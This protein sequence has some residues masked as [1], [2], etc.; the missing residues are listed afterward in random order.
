MATHRF[1]R[2]VDLVRNSRGLP[3][4]RLPS[5][6]LGRA[7]CLSLACPNSVWRRPPRT[8]PNGP[9]PHS[10][11]S[12]VQRPGPGMPPRCLPIPANLSE[13]QAGSAPVRPVPTDPCRPAGRAP[14]PSP[15]QLVGPDAA[16]R[17]SDPVWPPRALRRTQPRTWMD[18]KTPAS[19][20]QFGLS[21]H[22]E[23]L[24]RPGA[25]RSDLTQSG[26][27]RPAAMPPRDRPLPPAVLASRV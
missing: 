20:R 13:R 26:L 1:S 3:D 11:G 9:S 19:Y 21:G 27:A 22:A 14:L 4:G 16:A 12:L 15:T 5:S 8:S 24:P 2:S 25:W 6:R 18:R 23:T 10:Q 7:L 17:Q